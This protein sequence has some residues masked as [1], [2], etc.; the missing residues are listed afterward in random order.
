L[1]KPMTTSNR[2][3]P[4]QVRVLIFNE[5]AERYAAA[6]AAFF[7]SVEFVCATTHAE[8]L[9]QAAD[10]QVLL[11]YAHDMSATLAAAAPR[12]NWIQALTTGVDAIL[13]MPDLRP[14]IMV[15]SA[16]GNHGPQ[17]AEMAF[18]H[19]L[20][21]ARGARRM[22]RNQE[23]GIWER[24]PQPLLSQKTVTVVGIGAVAEALAKRCKA[25]DM[26]VVG[27]SSGERT[28]DNFDRIV[29]RDRLREAAARADF[30]VMLVPYSAATNCIIDGDVLA[31][32]KPDAFLINL[33]RGGV[34]DESALIASLQ[35]HSI[36]GAGLDVFAV[37]PLPPNHPF[38]RMENVLMSPHVGG[39]SSTYVEQLTPLLRA[40]LSAYLQGRPEAM[41]NR[42][43]R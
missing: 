15:T 12:L 30:L 11:A 21:L 18:L 19:M 1:E 6:L 31:C 25:F 22:W 10:A 41:S 28:L 36:A 23:E 4:P 16:R 8:A 17:M 40:N 37:E 35:R 5:M 2:P 33:A 26:T 39:L 7:P 9:Q 20:T 14:G 38:W 29:G 24:W 27:V 34:V 13:G 3:D 42:V 43:E 32:M